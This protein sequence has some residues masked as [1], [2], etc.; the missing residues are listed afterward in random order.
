VD[1]DSFLSRLKASRL[2]TEEQLRDVEQRFPDAR[3]DAAI[4]QTLIAAGS[5]TPYQAQHI[6]SDCERPLVLGQYRILEEV[7]RG[8]MGHVYKALHTVMGRVVAIKIIAPELVKDPHVLQLF[9]REVQAVTL[10]HH[11][12]IATAYDA[13][14]CDGEHFLVMEYVDGPD[15]DAVVTRHGGLPIALACSVVR[16]TAEAL[17]YA[18][19]KGMVHR[20]I[21]PANVLLAGWDESALGPWLHDRTA[22]PP[23]PVP[24]PI[25]KVLD[26]GIARL[27]LRADGDTLPVRNPGNVIGTPDY[28]AP[29]QAHNFHAADTRSDLYSLGCTFYYMLSGRVPFPG[30]S[31]LEKVLHHA[32]EDAPPLAT[33]RPDVPADVSAIVRRLMDKDP[34]QRF[35]TPGELA[36]ALVPWCNPRAAAPVEEASPPEGAK[37]RTPVTDN[38]D[39][40]AVADESLTEAWC[41]WVDVVE[42]FA[43]RRGNRLGISDTEYAGLHQRAVDACRA[44]EGSAAGETR[45]RFADL[46]Q[47]VAPWLSLEALA[48]ADREILA[49]LLAHCQHLEPLLTGGR[50]RRSSQRI[51]AA[52]CLGAAALLALACWT[53]N[54]FGLLKPRPGDSWLG[55]FLE[56]ARQLIVTLGREIQTHPILWG[57]ALCALVL[58]LSIY[59]V[60]RLPR[61]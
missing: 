22:A 12:N 25:V 7:G 39:G 35:Q 42:G 14:E 43:R 20:D 57:S 51:T 24:L 31:A 40:F 29:E 17:Q 4:A 47:R 36:R 5:L 1:R 41:R 9:R 46:R 19:E 60:A 50:R 23:T 6:L 13:N 11:P 3:R 18:H 30:E 53:T 21:K 26:F 52:V 48:R 28:I 55:S 33:F 16:Q 56:N 27:R 59:L 38:D 58:L 32:L 34:D 10:L 44:C 49:D 8:G 45:R 54:G 61:V 37:D 2:L 15:L